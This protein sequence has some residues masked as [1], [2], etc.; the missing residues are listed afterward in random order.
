[1]QAIESDI[2][3]I[4]L[5]WCCLAFVDKDTIERLTV[6]TIKYEVNEV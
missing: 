5:S 4:M 6:Q 2:I 3:K 1:M